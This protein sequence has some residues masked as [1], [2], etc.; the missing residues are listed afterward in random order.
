MLLWLLKGKCCSSSRKENA[1]LAPERKMLL[2]LQKG[3][4]CPGSRKENAALA[5]EGKI[6]PWLQNGKCCSGSASYRLAYISA[7]LKTFMHFDAA[8]SSAKKKNTL[9]M[10][11]VTQHCIL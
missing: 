4:Y 2:W 3:K 7:Q 9:F 10:A 5:P 8:P 6:L 11:P 1:A